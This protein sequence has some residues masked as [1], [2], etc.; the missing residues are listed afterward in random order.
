MERGR[1]P[2]AVEAGARG[3]AMT[4]GRAYELAALVHHAQWSLDHEKDGRARAA[5]LRFAR[6]GV[7]RLDDRLDLEGAKALADDRPMPVA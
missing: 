3:F 5:A 6:H 7:D 2:A 4:L 1:D